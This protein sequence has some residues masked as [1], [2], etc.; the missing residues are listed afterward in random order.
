MRGDT[1]RVS[2]PPSS[3][4]T[5]LLAAVKEI[6][7]YVAAAWDGPPRLFALARATSLADVSDDLPDDVAASVAD[8][9][10]YLIGIE[11]EGFAT[12]GTDLETALATIAWP[13]TVDGAALAVERIVVP[14][15]AESDLPEDPRAALD[16]LAA[17]P[18]RQDVRL[19]VGVLR[20]GETWCALR[21][22][23]HDEAS[24][25]AFGP[26]LVPGLTAALAATL[27]G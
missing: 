7:S 18:Q 13:E 12:D 25:V 23:D 15:T 27:E 26:D 16:A 20:T 24:A 8:D 21:S 2:T 19:V 3:P 22:R 9:P 1:G 6:E 4:V 5:P 14:P 10:D 17:H 11:Q